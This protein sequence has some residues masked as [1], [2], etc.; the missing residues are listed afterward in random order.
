MAQIDKLNYVPLLV[1]FLVFFVFFYFYLLIYVL[2]F[3]FGALRVRALFFNYLVDKLLDWVFFHGSF[4][5]TYLNVA[6]FSIISFLSSFLV[7][8]YYLDHCFFFFNGY[9]VS[10][11]KV[12]SPEYF[13]DF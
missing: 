11:A 8:L 6:P 7:T 2:P 5:Y 1:W 13:F 12:G 4:A 9:L 3:I 10:P